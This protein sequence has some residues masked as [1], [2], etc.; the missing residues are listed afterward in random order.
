MNG[1]RSLTPGTVISRR[2]SGEAS[3]SWAITDSSSVIARKEVD[4]AQPASDR[5]ALLL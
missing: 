1:V 2:T 3:A 4:V 5:L